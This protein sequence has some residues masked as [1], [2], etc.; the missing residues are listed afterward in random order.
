MANPDNVKFG[1]TEIDASSG[2]SDP[3]PPIQSS[4]LAKLRKI[5]QCDE[6]TKLE[7][8]LVLATEKIKEHLEV[9]KGKELAGIIET[10]ETLNLD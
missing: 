10:L 6:N 5:L 1:K 7:D 9:E 8:M 3:Y 4:D 2:C